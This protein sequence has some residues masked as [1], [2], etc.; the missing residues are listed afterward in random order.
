MAKLVS[1]VYG[2]ALFEL[3]LEN[4]QLDSLTEEVKAVSQ[5]LTENE[6]LTKLMNHPKIDKEEKI[7]FI[8]DVFTGRVSRELVGLMRM[9]VEKGHYNEMVTV[10]DYFIGRVKEY[11]NIGTAYVTSAF[12]LSDA[13]KA[14]L[15]KRL[16]ETTRYVRFEMHFDVDASLIGG[17]VIRSGDRIVDSSVKNKLNQLTRELQK[18]QL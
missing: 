15:A 5:A 1:T 3:A 11:K 2:D 17:M 13:Q 7:K 8:E 14:A 16:L 4:N 6:D 18:I 9:L 10:F 12:P